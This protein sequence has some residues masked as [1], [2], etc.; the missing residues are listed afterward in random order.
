MPYTASLFIS[1]LGETAERPEAVAEKMPL[2]WTLRSETRNISFLVRTYL[3]TRR[4]P[5]SNPARIVPASQ[6]S[7]SHFTAEESG[8]SAP[9]ERGPAAAALLPGAEDPRSN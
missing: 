5:S 2:L 1:F 7:G 9:T 6:D 3:W 8:L 4:S